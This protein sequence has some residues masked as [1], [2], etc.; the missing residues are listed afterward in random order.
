MEYN[1]KCIPRYN[2]IVNRKVARYVKRQRKIWKYY[3]DR[4]NIPVQEGGIYTSH[5]TIERTWYSYCVWEIKNVPRIKTIVEKYLELK[6][7]LLK[8]V[9][10]I[11]QKAKNSIFQN[12]VFYDLLLKYSIGSDNVA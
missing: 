3:F 10:L 2:D 4:I 12:E 8:K 6:K 9:F 1:L 5:A 11:L 7:L